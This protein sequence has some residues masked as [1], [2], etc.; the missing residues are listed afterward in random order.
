[1]G[2]NVYFPGDD[3]N[4]AMCWLVSMRMISTKTI[5]ELY[6][7][8]E[9]PVILS[10]LQSTNYN[11]LYKYCLLIEESLATKDL[12]FC[13][14]SLALGSTST[15]LLQ[16]AGRGM[17]GAGCGAWVGWGL[18]WMGPEASTR[19]QLRSGLRVAAAQSGVGQNRG[20]CPALSECNVHRRGWG[21]SI[22]SNSLAFAFRH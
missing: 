21:S 1:V 16:R 22:K 17:R 18:G 10:A 20:H 7:Y 6:Y 2:H 13:R 3:F 9:L 12:R 4:T 5:R 14:I 11:L 15:W 19:R 8:R